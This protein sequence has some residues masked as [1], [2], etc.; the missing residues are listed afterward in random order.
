[1]CDEST[2]VASRKA[3]ATRVLRQMRKTAK[4]AFELTGTP[5]GNDPTSLHSQLA[6]L[7]NG[8]ALGETLGLYRAA[9]FSEHKNYWGGYEYT[10]KKQME[11]VLHRFLAHS[12]IRIEVDESDLPTF[13][14]V[15]KE[16][17]LPHATDVYVEKA[18]KD[19]LAAAKAHSFQE[20][21]NAFLKVRQISSGFLGYDNDETG[22]RAQIEFRPNPKMEMLLSLLESIPEQHKVIVFHDYIFAGSM[23]TRE[24]TKAGIS[25]ARISGETKEHDAILANFD[26]P[27]GPRVLVLNNRFSMGPNLQAAKYGI[28]Y[29]NPTSCILKKQGRRRFERQGSEHKKVFGYEIVARGTYDQRILDAHKAGEDLFKSIIEGQ[30]KP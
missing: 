14:S 27:T 8:H 3:L 20:T 1:V 17:V 15:V 16:V 22:K 21:K 30:S 2:N 28:W 25:W 19:L 9:F 7:D 18:R 29:E 6:L 26:R 5:F 10:F 23:I 13:V 12:S 11:P 4:F 24:L